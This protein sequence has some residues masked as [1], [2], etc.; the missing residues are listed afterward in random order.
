MKL[1]NSRKARKNS[2]SHSDSLAAVIPSLSGDL[3]RYLVGKPLGLGRDVSTSALR[4]CA[5]HDREWK[6][7]I[8]RSALFGYSVSAV[9]DYYTYI[10]TNKVRSVLYVGVTNGLTKRVRQ[11]RLGKTEGFTRRY[12][13]DRLVYFEH[14]AKPSEAIAREKQ[15]K[16]W[17]RQKKEELIAWQN[18][19]WEDLAITVLGLSA[20]PGRPWEER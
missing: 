4:A 9:A 16:G 8:V 15:L 13:C 1:R 11:H 6:H 5:Q 7:E 14:F 2:Y 19:R 18:P 3:G 10:L 12:H 20:P 17:R